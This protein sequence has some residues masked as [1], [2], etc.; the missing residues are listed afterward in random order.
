MRTMVSSD[1]KYDRYKHNPSLFTSQELSGYIIFMTE[2]GDCFHCH[3]DPLFTINQYKNNGL[4]CDPQGI[5]QGR[6]QVTHLTTDIGKFKVPTLRNI[7]L[8]APYMHDGRYQTLEEVV[9]FYNSGVCQ[10]SPN[11]DPIMTKPA[12]IYGLQ[13]A[14]WEKADLVA[15]LKTL[16][17][18]TFMNNPNFADPF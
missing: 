14:D 4:D 9:E 3:G 2:R 18:S 17:D 15:F 1:S 11:I 8:T 10:N 6:Y 16:T 7:E 12:K 5:N 13:L